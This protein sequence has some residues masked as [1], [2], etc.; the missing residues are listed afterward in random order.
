MLRRVVIG[1]LAAVVVVVAGGAAYVWFSGGSGE[2]STEI[3]APPIATPPTVPQTEQ[4]PETTTAPE[5]TAPAASTA[6]AE[7]PATTTGAITF[8]ISQDLSTASYRIGEILRGVDNV[9]VGTTDQVAA[10]LLVDFDNPS[11]AQLGTVVINARTFTTDSEFRDRAVRSFVLQSAGEEFEFMTF[12]PT[13]I[14]GL[15][16]SL[17]GGTITFAVTGD[18]TIRAV[19][20]PVTFQVEL[21]EASPDRIVGVATA[22]VTRTAFELTIPNVQ[23]VAG[24]ED[25]VELKLEFVALP[26]D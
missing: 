8:E 7:T 16:E 13:S 3:N 11:A 22:K 19:T 2:P 5:G 20:Q 17:D 26:S 23:Q 25:E 18:L 14:D 1:L 21:S 6:P 24:V 15:P 4:P 9:V 12:E 10:Q